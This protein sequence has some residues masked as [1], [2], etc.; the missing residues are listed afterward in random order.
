MKKNPILLFCL[1]TLVVV[2]V[3]L[4]YY[5]GASGASN[6]S[7]DIRN[8]RSENKRL[9]KEIED[10][11]KALANLQAMVES[12]NKAAQQA[13][14]RKSPTL[15]TPVVVEEKK[16]ERAKMTSEEVGL[17][18]RNA[19]LDSNPITR[20]VVFSQLLADLDSEN[21][22]AVLEVYE[23]I[24]MGFENMHEY[25]MLLY[26]WGKF[27]PSGAIEYC[28]KRAT[29]IGAGFA[30][31][32]VLHGWASSDPQAALAWV[33]APEN[34]GMSKIYNFGLVRGWASQ[35]LTAATTY[36]TDLD[37]G[38]D[39]HE[40]VKILTTE[41]LKQGFSPTRF[42]VE[43][44]EDE[45]MKKSAFTNLTQ[46]RSRE[47]PEEV[48]QWLKEH[49]GKEYADA[50]FG[51]LGDNWGQRDPVAAAKYFDELPAG[52]GKNEGMR[53]VVEHWAKDDPEATGNWLN[54]KEPSA[55]MDPIY[56]TYA[57]QVS[58]EDGAGAMQWA[59]SITEPK[60]QKR[61]ITSVG[62]NWYRQDKDSV[63]TWL[64]ESGL[65]EETQEAIRK[66]PKKNWWQSL[67][68]KKSN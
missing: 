55:D 48:A 4:G 6:E 49:A 52:E 18:L 67:R 37:E 15:E 54:E 25:Q 62:Q 12:S 59:V 1:T 24:P 8:L 11:E 13:N 44:M 65:P 56:A 45:N 22:E 46:Q 51:R 17:A 47:H 39:R 50:S 10:H 9:E 42:W 16:D 61:T 35:D 27:D 40:L 31:A 26:G 43:S 57:R 41:Q 30:T 29:G 28:N 34:E 66:P 2:G 60:L 53:E 23:D 20:S 19:F 5:W 14:R 3:S 63:E 58:E 32:G 7:D 21:L 64:P 33:R 68:P 36:V 38:G